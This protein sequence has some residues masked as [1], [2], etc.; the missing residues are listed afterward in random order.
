MVHVFKRFHIVRKK[1]RIKYIAVMKKEGNK[2]REKGKIMKKDINKIKK[3]GKKED[4]KVRK[5]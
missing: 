1:S 3:R 4:Q 2:S 5:K